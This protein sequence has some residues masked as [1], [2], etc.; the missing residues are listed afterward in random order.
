MSF[1]FTV[2]SA[3]PG[4]LLGKLWQERVLKSSENLVTDAQSGL[5]RALDKRYVFLGFYWGCQESLRSH[6]NAHQACQLHVSMAE[7]YFKG[8]LSFG[9]PKYSPLREPIDYW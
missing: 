2:Q 9:L 8:G 7:M 5:Q 6:F 3:E 1:L 4:T